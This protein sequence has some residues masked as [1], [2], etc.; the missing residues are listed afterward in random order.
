MSLIEDLKREEG[1]RAHAYQD[2][3][4]FWT[5][6]YGTCIDERVKG[7]G[8]TEEEAHDLLVGKL[9][10]MMLELGDRWPPFYARPDGVRWALQAMAYQMG[11]S[12][13]LGFK[14]MLSAL[15]A[16]DYATAA[17]EALDSTWANQTPAR[18]KRV[19]AQIAA[20]K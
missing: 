13:L 12:K 10:R 6:G 15:E 20:G 4:G 14:K 5:I 11:V 2:H 19:A 16:G 8:L 9:H 1:F 18:A 17:A 3:L 7:C